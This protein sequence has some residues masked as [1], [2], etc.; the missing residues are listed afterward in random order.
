MKKPETK[1]LMIL[2][3]ETCFNTGEIQHINN[4]KQKEWP[5]QTLK[6][7]GTSIPRGEQ[8]QVAHPSLHP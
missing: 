8:T 6:Y 2:S 4:L 7:P 3:I 5:L 1:N